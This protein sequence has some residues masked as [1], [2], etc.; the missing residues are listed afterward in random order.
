MTPALMLQLQREL[1][2]DNL[3]QLIHL[4]RTFYDDNPLHYGL[5][6]ALAL[7]LLDRWWDDENNDAINPDYYQGIQGLREP[8]VALLQ[9]PRTDS[10]LWIA[11][12]EA[13]FRTWKATTNLGTGRQES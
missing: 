9:T 8:L 2:R 11:R 3:Q 12:L 6:Y 4:C 1:T 5:C 10:A 13:V 7:S